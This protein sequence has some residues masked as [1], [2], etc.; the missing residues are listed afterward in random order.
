MDIITLLNLGL[1]V[2]LIALTAF[3]VGSEF[4]VVKI[5]MSRLDQLIAEGNKKAITAK[6]VAG[7]L[8]YY[9]SACQLGI[10]V[11]ALGLGALGKPTVERLMY[12]IFEYFAVSDAVASAAS[13][14][15][16]FMLVTYLHVVLG[17][18]APKTLA[19][20]YAEK[21]SL[22]LAPPLYWFGKIMKPFIWALNGAARVL[23]RTFGV[24]P[25]GHD[26]AYSEDELKI[27][28][29]QSFEGGELNETELS[30]MENVFTFDERSAKDI[31]VP[32]TELVTLDKD[33]PLEE[34]VETLDE[35]NYTRYP[36]TEEGD[37]D[38]II[39][40]VSAKKMLPHIVAGR[41]WKLQEFVRELPTVFEQTGLQD[42]LLKMQQAR[43]HIAIVADEYGGT[44]GMITLED[45]LEEI[46]GEIRDEFDADEQ[47]EISQVSDHQYLI[48]GRMLLRDLEERFGVE[49]EESDDI[50]TIGGWIHY[51]TAG[52]V[53]TGETLT[54]ESGLWTVT[55]MDNQQIK[56]VM[57]HQNRK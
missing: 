46:V 50:D 52:E 33:M 36:V 26:Q 43:V 20:E 44:A 53:Q 51:K 16:A 47:P 19:I 22:L 49:F 12:P 56:Q 48:N 31:M 32:R 34:I 10:T 11:T 23:L 8:D 17:E 24:Q 54:E 14:A 28:M 4:A 37:K 5:R 25:A 1:L 6:K 13:Y 39:G 29:A 18:M 40:F 57:F 38:R 2:I 9:L 21:M 15:I 30:Y 41:P 55:E 42:A 3:F 45:I 7:D 27:V 35:N